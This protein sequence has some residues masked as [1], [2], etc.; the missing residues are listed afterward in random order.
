MIALI[1]KLHVAAGKEAEFE[2]VMLG[3]VAE[4]RK[5]EEG[6]RLFTLCKDA[7]GQYCQIEIYADEAA[8]TAHM[9]SAHFKASGPKFAGVMAG[10]PEIQ[11]LTVVG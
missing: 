6:N 7:S 8:L 11:K 3:L 9:H 1:A 4:V 5:N 10:R 2:Q